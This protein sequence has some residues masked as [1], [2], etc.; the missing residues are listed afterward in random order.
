[1]LV[2]AGALRTSAACYL[3]PAPPAVTGCQTE[4]HNLATEAATNA[5]VAAKLEQ[6]QARL[7]E[8][9]AGNFNPDRGQ[10]DSA[11]CTA[12]EAYGGYYGPFV[13][14]TTAKTDTVM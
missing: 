2:A 4:H 13:T 14:T 8:L 5:T 12:A 9:N 1:M 10:E 6:L 11:A 7:A 3:P